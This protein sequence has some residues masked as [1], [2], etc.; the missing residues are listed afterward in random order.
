MVAAVEEAARQLAPGDLERLRL[1]VAFADLLLAESDAPAARRLLEPAL[2]RLSEAAEA[3]DA[4]EATIDLRRKAESLLAAALADSGELA[5]AAERLERL[6]TEERRRSGDG[7]PGSGGSR[8]STGSRAL[9]TYLIELAITRSNL[10][11]LPAAEAAYLEALAIYRRIYGETHVEVSTLLRN[12]SVT[13]QNLGR[14]DAARAALEEALAIDRRLFG[15]RHRE[16]ATDLATL[17]FALHRD[18]RLEEARARYVE[19]LEVWRALP[20]ASRDAASAHTLSNYGALLLALDRP[21]EAEPPLREA[22]ERY[23]AFAS[24]EAMRPAVAAGRLGVALVGLGRWRE[25]VERLA[26]AVPELE[27]TFYSWGRAG[28]VDM[29]LAHARAHLALGEPEPAR[30]I[31]AAVRAHLDPAAEG[32]EWRRVAARLSELEQVAAVARP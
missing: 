31:L 12:L 18:G 4:R 23:A 17:G 25:G 21:A 7:S 9:G 5:A 10:G 15:D 19:S 13:L 32:E 28:F 22:V 2:A 29:Q 1:E 27:P 26:A 24:N 30:A 6:V 20:D 16:V 3:A 11:E 14:S 8:G